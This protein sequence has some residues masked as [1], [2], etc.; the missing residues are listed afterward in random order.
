MSVNDRPFL[1]PDDIPA[2]GDLD[3][4]LFVPFW[5]FANGKR[6]PVELVMMTVEYSRI[7]EHLDSFDADP[8]VVIGADYD[9]R[10]ST[11]IRRHGRPFSLKICGEG[12][13]RIEQQLGKDL[14]TW[15]GCPLRLFRAR[16]VLTGS[17]RSVD[18]IGVRAM[19]R[20]QRVAAFGR[21]A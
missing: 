8:K 18:Y 16:K 21:L 6:G 15:P 1:K 14:T 4:V 19:T 11:E 12:W 20:P 2:L 7:L 10:I 9:M 3:V 5:P 17:K 13:I